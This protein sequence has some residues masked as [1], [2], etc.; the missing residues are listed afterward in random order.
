MKKDLQKIRELREMPYEEYLQTKQWKNKAKKKRARARYRCQL[1]NSPSD[2]VVHHR[3]YE[4]R[5][6]ETMNDLTLLC[7]E[8]H[9]LFHKHRSL[10]KSAK[11]RE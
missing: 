4:N 10:Y 7:R 5:G 9:A 3:T 11:E 6:D 2:P 1:C 8:C